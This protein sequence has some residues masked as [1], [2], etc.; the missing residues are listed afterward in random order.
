MAETLAP[1]VQ[2]CRECR[3]AEPSVLEPAVFILWGK[4]FP[5]EAL[6]PKCYD[7]AAEH[8]GWSNM[9]RI[10]QWAVFDLR[11]LY[12]GAPHGDDIHYVPAVRENL[13]SP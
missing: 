8:V 13:V 9:H 4:L 5:P 2:F 11:G 10:D 1:V 3:D 12:R 7:H 6:G